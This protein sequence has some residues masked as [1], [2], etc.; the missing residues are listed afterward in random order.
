M[1][2]RQL[3]AGLRTAAGELEKSSAGPREAAKSYR[4]ARLGIANMARQYPRLDA[5]MQEL[6]RRL[7]TARRVALQL[8]SS[9]DAAA[10]QALEAAAVAAG[11]TDATGPKRRRR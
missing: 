11:S 1:T 7:E 6:D 5:S 9:V 2:P 4:L 3:A 8:A 10:A